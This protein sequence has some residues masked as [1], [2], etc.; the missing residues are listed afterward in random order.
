[1]FGVSHIYLI[2]RQKAFKFRVKSV[3]FVLF[4]FGV[5]FCLDLNSADSSQIVFEKWEERRLEVLARVQV[6]QTVTLAGIN[7]K[8]GF[9]LI[10]FGVP[11]FGCLFFLF[12]IVIKIK[13]SGAGIRTH[14]L[15][16]ASRL[17]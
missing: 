8:K 9:K 17:P 12:F 10:I 5:F 4:C 14:D 7:L 13:G 2:K 1:M 6:T 11:H 16:A 15:S 3:C